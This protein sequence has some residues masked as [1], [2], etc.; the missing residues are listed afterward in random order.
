MT[1]D[2][3]QL[4]H[5]AVPQSE[6]EIAAL[7]LEIDSIDAELVRL[8]KQRTAISHAIGAA[9]MK[10]GGPRVVHS[11][12]MK[13]LDRFRDLGQPGVDLALMLL[14]L[15]RGKLGRSRSS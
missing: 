12:E 14:D 1:E 4:P 2:R 15:G 9:R 8:I 11:R 5:V 7:R 10:L 13:I 6:D 3:M